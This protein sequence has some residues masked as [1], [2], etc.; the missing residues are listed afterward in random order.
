M[1]ILYKNKLLKLVKQHGT[2]LILFSPDAFRKKY[3]EL[4]LHLPHVKHHYALKSLPYESCLQEIAACN[5]FL[6]LASI[7]EIK[8]VHQNRPELIKKSIY[9]H[10]IKKSKDIAL[11]LKYGI[12]TM[13]ADN[14]EEL[15]K[16]IEYGSEIQ[17][18]L[19]VAFPNP[20]ARCDLSQKFGIP[21]Q[22]IK[23][24]IAYC[25]DSGLN[26]HG[27]SFH[28]G[29]QLV[30]P[31]A[32]INGIKS[33]KSIYEW[34]NLNYNYKIPVL[35]IGGGFPAKLSV[36]VPDLKEFCKPI[37]AILN[38]L[39][40]DTEIWSEPG[41][42][43]SASSMMSISSI[44]GKTYKNN[45][46]WYYIDDGVYQTLSGKVYDHAE[47]SFI[48][49]HSE[50]SITFSTV[51]SGPTCDSIDTLIN[52][53]FLPELNVG[54]IFITPNVG[55]YGWASRTSFNNLEEAKIIDSNFEI[56]EIIHLGSSTLTMSEVA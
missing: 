39:F 3:Q 28:P 47:Y 42:A 25:V 33:L 19:R 41:R 14:Y 20:S 27:I 11:A 15:Y 8:M 23:K 9:T 55:A 31:E 50:E 13:V 26:L 2:P 43:I 29:S 4:Q 12:N 6:D 16:F 35:D 37:N 10:P 1:N 56:E 52:K 5:G 34:C 32:H 40:P 51:I 53:V 21:F 45:Q 46:L 49:L 24:L 38:E 7:G 18:L 36:E 54:D 17:V 44:V 22:D 30:D 48:P